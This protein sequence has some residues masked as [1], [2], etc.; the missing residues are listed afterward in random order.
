MKTKRV[1][2]YNNPNFKRFLYQ[3]KFQAPDGIIY[4]LT[5]IVCEADYFRFFRTGFSH[6]H[7][8]DSEAF[9]KEVIKPLFKLIMSDNKTT[10]D[11]LLEKLGRLHWFLAHA[12]LYNR[13][14]AAITENLMRSILLA[15]INSAPPF[16]GVKFPDLE[17]LTEP[18]LLQYEKNFKSTMFKNFDKSCP[19]NSTK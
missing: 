9:E 7:P 17:A 16:D 18:D 14:S 15:K 2:L 19:E 4:P 8:D 13:G 3:F 6:T 10:R 5:Q 11:E 12:M 1:S